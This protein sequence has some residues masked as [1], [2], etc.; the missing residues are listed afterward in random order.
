MESVQT[1][2]KTFIKVDN[3]KK[4]YTAFCIEHGERFVANFKTEVND[5]EQ[6]REIGEEIA[7]TWGAECTSVREWKPCQYVRITLAGKQT[8]LTKT[9]WE[10]W[11]RKH[12]NHAYT[13]QADG[14]EPEPSSVYDYDIE[15]AKEI[16]KYPPTAKVA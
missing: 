9:S 14:Q 12:P 13:I 10:K 16:A 4:T 6:L 8:R 7:S 2:K 15:K 3:M 1:Y 11:A 5:K